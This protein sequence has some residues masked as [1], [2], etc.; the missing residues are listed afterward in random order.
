[1]TLDDLVA[2]VRQ[3]RVRAVARAIS[4]VEDDHP[5]AP[6]LLAALHDA[7]R[8]ALIVGVTGP[9]GAGK[10]TLVDA[11]AA[12]LR[13]AGQRVGILA[14]DPSSPFSGGALLGDRIRMHRH[15]LDPDVFVRSM[16]TRGHLGGLARGATDAARILSAA[17]Y[18][19]VIV[20]TVG[21]GQAE[22]D[23][24]RTADVSLVVLVPGTGDDVQ[25]LK[26]GV[27]EI[28][29]VFVV[30]KADREGADRLVASIDAMLSLRRDDD[31]AGDGDAGRGARW[32]PPVVKTTATTG[33]GIADVWAAIERFRAHAAVHGGARRRARV[34]HH[35]RARLA[36]RLVPLVE[37]ALPAAGGAT[38]DDV[39][40]AVAD[41]RQDPASA[42]EA[43]V[44]PIAAAAR[45]TAAR[46]ADDRAEAATPPSLDHVGIAVQ[47]PRAAVAFFCEQLGLPQTAVETV[48]AQGVRVQFLGS[49]EAR[50]ELLEPLAADTPVG[51]FLDKRGPGLHH[52]A[53]VVDDLDG[54]LHAL[55]A[56]G[57]RLIDTTPRTGAGGAR[58]AFVH[59]ASTGGVLVELK[60]RR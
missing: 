16:A 28:A 54:R 60:E 57:V 39:V 8:Q 23:I 24:V 15:A 49:G 25:A 38:F 9:P 36:D 5:A 52:V 48:E 27:M 26:A 40:A 7:G 30:N 18:D 58:I 12:H 32:R 29:D 35:L 55:A 46:P 42:V 21:V 10:S 47:D 43:L 20:E 31:G 1:M 33:D 53:L 4:L 11:L 50:L 17:G 51:R 45:R 13:A 22:V 14:V 19:T 41:G 6:A 37:A 3:G 44:A 34:A 59:P 2:H 56:A